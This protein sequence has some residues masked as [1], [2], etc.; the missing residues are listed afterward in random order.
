MSINQ[1]SQKTQYFNLEAY[2][3]S[4]GNLES[5]KTLLAIFKKS[6]KSTLNM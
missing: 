4:L 3:V 2:F 6:I 5:K 1:E